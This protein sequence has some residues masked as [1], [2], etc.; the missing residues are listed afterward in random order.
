MR[1]ILLVA[2]ILVVVVGAGLFIPMFNPPSPATD[3]RIASVSV[4]SIGPGADRSLTMSEATIP[5]G[6]L[7]FD[8][9]ASSSS[10]V[11]LWLAGPC[12]IGGGVCPVGALVS[13]AGGV[14]GRWMANGPINATYLVSVSNQGAANVTFFATLTATYDVGA[15][16]QVIP[17]WALILAGALILLSMGGIAVFLG[18]FL[19]GGVY[20]APRSDRER[21]E[22]KDEEPP[23]ATGSEPDEPDGP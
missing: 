11:T 4:S 12:P 22:G 18:L 9:T 21:P 2:G 10:N 19:P 15:P 13:W 20:G 8:W 5:S 6:T 1:R 7:V 16:T 23:D 3:T 14:N 17:A